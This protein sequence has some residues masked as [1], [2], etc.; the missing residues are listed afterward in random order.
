MTLRLCPRKVA[1]PRSIVD[2]M[3]LQ[4][5]VAYSLKARTVEPE[6]QPLLANGSETTFFFYASAW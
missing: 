1:L 2:D 6:K 4:D 3:W 5:I